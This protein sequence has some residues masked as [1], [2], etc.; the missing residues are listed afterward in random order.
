MFH[1]AKLKV[2]AAKGSFKVEIGSAINCK[3]E[4]TST[5]NPNY[6][7]AAEAVSTNTIAGLDS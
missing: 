4:V 1:L 3:S 2:Q 7:K 6:T 5:S